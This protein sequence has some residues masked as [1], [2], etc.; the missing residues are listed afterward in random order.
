MPMQINEKSQKNKKN[1]SDEIKSI[2]KDEN[3][4]AN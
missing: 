2:I 1:K 4:N 3:V